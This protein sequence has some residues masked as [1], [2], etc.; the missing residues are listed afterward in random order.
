[1]WQ[2]PKCKR[3]FSNTNQSHYCGKFDTVDDYIFAQS[4][5]V[6]AVLRD[7][8]RVIHEAAPLF[9]KIAWNMPYFYHKENVVGFAAHKRHISLFPG[10]AAVCEFAERLLGYK[11]NK[12]TIQLPLD[13][14]VDFALVGDIVRWAANRAAC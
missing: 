1:M 14:P 5:D 11:F 4:G 9:E 13:R 12:G 7:L 8:R 6:Q 3:E 2:C 10:D